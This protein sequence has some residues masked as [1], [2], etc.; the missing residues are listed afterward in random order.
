MAE[1]EAHIDQVLK[2][3]KQFKKE[4]GLSD[5]AAGEG[6]MCAMTEKEA[7]EVHK[8]SESV[9]E[10]S[11]SKSKSRW[12][13]LKKRVSKGVHRAGWALHK[14]GVLGPRAR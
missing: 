1:R 3:V 9:K 10:V 14:L 13:K 11:G 7:E 2:Q 12:A 8:D 5:W 6:G 4:T